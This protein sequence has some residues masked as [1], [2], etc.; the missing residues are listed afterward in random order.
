M[1]EK[2]IHYL[3][4]VVLSGIHRKEILA[5]NLTNCDIWKQYF[6]DYFFI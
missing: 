4:E 5:S 2:N 6:F 1:I 3:N